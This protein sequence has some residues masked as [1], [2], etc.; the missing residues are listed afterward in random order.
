MYNCIFQYFFPVC[1]ILSIYF[2]KVYLYFREI[3]LDSLV[4]RRDIRLEDVDVM[5]IFNKF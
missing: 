4:S 5:Y 1:L 2:Y 3:L